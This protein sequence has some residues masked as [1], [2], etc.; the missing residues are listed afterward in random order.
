MPSITQGRG[1]F[2]WPQEPRVSLFSTS[3]CSHPH[4]PREQATSDLVLGTEVRG[5][6]IFLCS[7]KNGRVT[8][9]PNFFFFFFL[10][11]LQVLDGP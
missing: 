4:L 11:S 5:G 10:L 3:L 8:P 9:Y 1:P 2:S 6:A 7:R